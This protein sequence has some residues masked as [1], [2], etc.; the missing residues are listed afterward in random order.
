MA[1]S[2]FLF[3]LGKVFFDGIARKEKKGAAEVQNHI[4][5][6]LASSD[7]LILVVKIKFARFLTTMA[8]LSL[9]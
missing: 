2:I 5:T 7:G 8:F 4:G 3:R 9:G 1:V 6:S